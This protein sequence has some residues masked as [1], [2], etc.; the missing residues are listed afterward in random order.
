MAAH[1]PSAKLLEVC[2]IPMQNETL[3]YQNTYSIAQDQL[4][5]HPEVDVLYLTNGLTQ[6]AAAAVKSSHPQKKVL[7]FGYECTEMTPTFIHEG[8]IGATIYQRP[9]QQWYNA[10]YM[11][12]EYLIGDRTINNPIFHSECS[13]IMEESLPLITIGGLNAL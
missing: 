12:Y 9:A 1:D 11:M 8:I 13:I 2:D 7:V 10:V 3:S 5:A 6:W 4:Q